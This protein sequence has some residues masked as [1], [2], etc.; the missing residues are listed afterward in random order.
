MSTT[1]SALRWSRSLS[2]TGSIAQLALRGDEPVMAPRVLRDSLFQYAEEGVVLDERDSD[3]AVL[4]V[5]LRAR[6]RTVGLLALAARSGRVFASAELTVAEQLARRAARALS[7]V[8]VAARASGVARDTHVALE[9]ESAALYAL[10]GGGE[11]LVLVAE[12]R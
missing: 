6:G 2:P 4:I 1:G 11:R 3:R 10:A 9:G 8:G 5:P 7:S 12:S